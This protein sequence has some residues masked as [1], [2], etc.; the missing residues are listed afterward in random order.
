MT[1]SLTSDCDELAVAT[2]PADSFVVRI[3]VGID[4]AEL[5]SRCWALLVECIS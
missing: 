5:E 1:P 2:D 4:R 3:Y